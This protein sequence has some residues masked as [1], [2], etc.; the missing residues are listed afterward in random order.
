MGKTGN[1]NRV[2][3]KRLFLSHCFSLENLEKQKQKSRGKGG[4][5]WQ[6]T[7]KPKFKK[8]ADSFPAW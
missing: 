5:L 3:D 7:G 2:K 4:T 1:Y 8:W 6:V